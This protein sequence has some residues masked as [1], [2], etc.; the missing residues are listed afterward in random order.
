VQCTGDEGRKL[1]EKLATLQGFRENICQVIF[2]F[3]GSKLFSQLTAYIAEESAERQTK[4]S[5][6]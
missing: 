6:G 5:V 1:R 2:Y 3:S 4:S